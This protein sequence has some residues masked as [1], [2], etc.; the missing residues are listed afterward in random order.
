[1]DV[2]RNPFFSRLSYYPKFS[3]F[4]LSP[5]ELKLVVAYLPPRLRY[6]QGD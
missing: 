5:T 3:P 2:D 4:Q 1:M 6:R